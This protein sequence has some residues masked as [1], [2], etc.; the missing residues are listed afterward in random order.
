MTK[1]PSPDCTLVIDQG[2]HA[3][4]CVLFD[5]HGHERASFGHDVSLHRDSPY[6]EQDANEIL[7]SARDTLREALDRARAERLQLTVA[8]LA[9]QRSTVIAWDRITGEPLAPA[10]SWQDTRAAEALGALEPQAAE[11]RER[12]GL[13]LSPHYG[14]S[15][16][17]WLLKEVPTVKQAAH[18]GRLALGPI[19]AFLLFHMVAGRP[20]R[21]DH[22]NAAR[23]LLLDLRTRHWD[24]W[25]LSLFGVPREHLPIPCPIRSP[26]GRLAGTQI[27]VGTVTGD[28]NAA[29]LSDGEPPSGTAFANL[30]S[31]AFVLLPC[32]SEP[33]ISPPLLTGL[34]DSVDDDA[35]YA[36][37]GTV[38][39]AGSALTWAR[40]TYQWTI[41]DSAL[42]E[43]LRQSPEPPLFINTVGGLGSP[44]WRVGVTP[45]W[46][47]GD[48][49]I[50]PDARQG[51]AAIVESIVFL[52]VENLAALGQTG[53]P[54]KRIVL[55]GG[56]SR[57]DGLCQRLA[58]LSRLSVLRRQDIEAT[59]RGAAW[60]ARGRPAHWQ[61]TP[62][63]RFEPRRDDRLRR[64]YRR[65]VR[66]IEEVICR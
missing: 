59:A 37:E 38:N 57:L 12:T 53:H 52:L 24:T 1:P 56:L 30:G 33:L 2:T 8:A 63:D 13:R 35:Q 64:R 25:L 22:A 51:L 3:T 40:N 4:R 58:D 61:P 26:Y 42:D 65:F 6:V 41:P 50:V 36:L 9:T 29:V 55:G 11:I 5:D 46:I 49:S 31:G 48:A 43:V 18:A 47:D 20:L 60:L 62:T 7:R 45:R 39:G 27:P 28:Q 66:S 44:W 15:K 16:L 34:I 10:L 32:G 14:A 54:I 17:S 21:V 23:M 19:A